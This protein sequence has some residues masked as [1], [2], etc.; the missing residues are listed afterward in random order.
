MTENSEKR[1][2]RAS[3]ILIGVFGFGLPLFAMLTGQIIIA[4]MLLS[5]ALGSFILISGLSSNAQKAD[6]SKAM[7]AFAIAFGV[8][9]F[10]AGL[11]LLIWLFNGAP[12]PGWREMR[13]IFTLEQLLLIL[14]FLGIN[15]ISQALRKLLDRRLLRRIHK[16]HPRGQVYTI[17]TFFTGVMILVLILIVPMDLFL[18]VGGI[19]SWLSR[20]EGGV[21]LSL[22]LG[23]PALLSPVL[24]FAI[25][26]VRHNSGAVVI[27]GQEISRYR[28]FSRKSL[29]LTEITE[30]KRNRFA[31]PTAV[32]LKSKVG[33]LRFP[34]SING[35]PE[36]LKIIQSYSG[37][38]AQ[39]PRKNTAPARREAVYFPYSLGMSRTRQALE[40][41]GA[42]LIVVIYLAMAFAGLWILLLR[43]DIPPVDVAD[44]L[45]AGIIFVLVSL[46]F[47]PFMVMVLEE[48]FN[49][50]NPTRI[51]FTQ[52]VIQMEYGRRKEKTF[53]ASQL[54]KFWLKPVSRRVRS[55][56]GGARVATSL[57]AYEL[58]LQIR[59]EPDIALTRAKLNG[60]QTTPEDLLEN[61]ES[62]YPQ[63]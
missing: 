27:D 49:P 44:L 2:V 63:V 32:L 15:L 5:L 8:F 30:I 40:A 41:F 33:K 14:G 22:G 3:R 47:G 57:Q 54:E 52:E 60:W 21:G 53:P 24:L 10:L 35:Y 62:L 19:A 11:G 50:K 7:K 43:G 4:G 25:G 18:I 39:S 37:L 28:Y 31:F 34:T 20:S 6:D 23:L 51:T 61:L 36:L 42:G 17:P 29:Q 55:S 59:G 48:R 1:K 13:P 45:A 26:M 12:I 38:S 9:Y 46:I 16:R 58:H 56:Y